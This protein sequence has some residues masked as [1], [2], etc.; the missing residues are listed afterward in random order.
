MS[1]SQKISELL[2]TRLCHDLTGPIGAV[3]NGV[4]F[5]EDDPSMQEHAMELISQSAKEAIAR[6]KFFRQAYGRINHSGEVS[7]AERKQLVEDYL[8]HSK[9]E[10]D[11]PDSHTDASGVAMSYKMARLMLNMII[12]V[13][14][15]MIR[16]GTLSIRLSEDANAK[17]LSMVGTADKIKEDIDLERALA[18]DMDIDELTP[19]LVQAHLSAELANEIGATLSLQV[20]DGQL[21]FTATKASLAA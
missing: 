6:L 7:L 15:L 12:I 8:A 5:M 10:L 20:Q 2:A 11:W 18:Q 16:G 21:H 13:T 17:T 1:D 14:H 3:N 19:K 9:L 4:E